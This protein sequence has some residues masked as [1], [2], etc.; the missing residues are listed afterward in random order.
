M[1]PG[2]QKAKGSRTGR[3]GAEEQRGLEGQEEENPEGYGGNVTLGRKWLLG[4]VKGNLSH[5]GR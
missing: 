4:E 3:G 2:W 1:S 5:R